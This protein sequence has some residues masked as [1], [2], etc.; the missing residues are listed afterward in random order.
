MG[1][2]SCGSALFIALKTLGVE[3]GDGVLCNAFSFTAVPSAI[4]HATATPVYVEST[5]GFVMDHEDLEKKITSDT[6]YLMLTHMRGKV[7]D[8]DKVY[9]LAEKHDL[10]VVEDCAHAIGIQWNGVQLGRRARVACF[11]SQSAKMINSG[12]GGFLCTDDEEIAAKAICYAGCYEKLVA[13]HLVAPSRAQRTRADSNAS[14][15]AK[16]AAAPCARAKCL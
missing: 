9:E 3:A 2:N 8:I 4:H 14:A 1:F 5:D 16:A 7:A 11:S 10:Q 15:D 13:H 6:R 12:E